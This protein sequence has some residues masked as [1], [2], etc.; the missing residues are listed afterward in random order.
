MPLKDWRT[1]SSL[2]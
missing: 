1:W 2:V